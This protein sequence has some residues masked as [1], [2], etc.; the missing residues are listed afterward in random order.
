M[1]IYKNR[2]VFVLGPNNMA[3]SP[4]TI[5]VQYTNGTNE[6]VSAGL[7][8]FTQ[9]EKD[10]LLKKYPSK[11]DNVQV[12]SKDDLEAVRTGV[13]PSFDPSVKEQARVDLQH[14]KQQ[15]MAQKQVDQAKAQVEKEQPKPVTNPVNPNAIPSVTVNQPQVKK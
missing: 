15:E 13:A 2:E 11:F 3:N 8:Y 6:N 9:E 1:A 14:K 12:A 7:V 5:Q 10:A 4:E